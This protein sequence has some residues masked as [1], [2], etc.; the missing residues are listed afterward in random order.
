[1]NDPY[2]EIRPYRDDEVP[3]V[4]QRLLSDPEFI[5][6]LTRLKFPFW[7]S[8]LGLVLK[9]LVALVLRRELSDVRDV[10]GFQMVVERYMRGMID[11]TTTGFSSSGLDALEPGQPWLFMSN[12]RDITLDPAFTNL[13]LHSS[14]HETVRI[15]IGDNLLTKPYVADLMRLNKSFI[16]NRSA[17][18]PRQILAAYRQLSSYIRHS[19]C[20]E[21]APVWIAQREG[22][23]KDGLDRT[24]PAIVKMLCMSQN[25]KTETL[26]E[27]V[28]SLRMVPVSIAYELDPCD[29]LKARELC[30]LARTGSYEK[31]EGE[32]VASIAAGIAGSKGLVH[33]AFG[34]PLAAGLDD[35]QDVAAA[36]DAQVVGNYRLHRTNVLAYQWLHGD[37]A[38]LPDSARDAPGSIGEQAFRE[39]IEALP[40]AHREYAL[41]IYANSVVAKLQMDAAGE[42]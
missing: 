9:P 11:S 12:H 42:V 34:Q 36:I 23:A 19:I 6:A 5:A 32:D 29:G 37:S 14:G 31:A 10:Y 7:A 25:K 24:E 20:E 39:R 26:A 15:A 13:A 22:R 3:A 2:A 41:A 33:V 40:E 17:Q 27:V 4:L 30:E 28:A 1:M 16:V 18:G 8:P 35:P 38:P 21:R